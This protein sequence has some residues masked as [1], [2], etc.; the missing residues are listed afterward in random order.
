[1]INTRGLGSSADTFTARNLLFLVPSFPTTLV[2]GFLVLDER[3][4]N[5]DNP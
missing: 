3:L 2:G 1:V 5:P 4:Y